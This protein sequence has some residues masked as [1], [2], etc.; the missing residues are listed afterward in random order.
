MRNLFGMIVACLVFVI[1]GQ[2]NATS[3][4]PVPTN[5]VNAPKAQ[6]IGSM[7]TANADKLNLVPT[8]VTPLNPQFKD[9][10]ACNNWLANSIGVSSGL[11]A[12]F[13]NATLQTSW[14][15]TGLVG[16]IG[17]CVDSQTGNAC[18]VPE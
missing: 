6:F 9:C 4:P 1:V 11:T 3:L 12:K 2:A 16:F 14:S 15:K 10:V 7:V 13:T 17:S 18:S 8:T 5:I